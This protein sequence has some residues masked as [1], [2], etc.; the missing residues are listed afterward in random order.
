MTSKGQTM[1]SDLNRSCTSKDQ[2]LNPDCTSPLTV[3]TNIS[4][5]KRSPSNGSMTFDH[6]RSKVVKKLYFEDEV[7]SIEAHFNIITTLLNDDWD[8]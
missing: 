5:H 3:Q 7:P 2:I 8:R 4:F 6:R 1:T